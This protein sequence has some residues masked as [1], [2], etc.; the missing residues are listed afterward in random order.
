[1]IECREKN[2]NK[3][4][5]ESNSECEEEDNITWKG[6]QHQV[7]KR[8]VVNAKRSRNKCEWVTRSQAPW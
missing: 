3:I 5:N 1:M 7:W 6:K 4:E 8:V 2:N